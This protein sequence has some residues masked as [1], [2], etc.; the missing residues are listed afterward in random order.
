MNKSTTKAANKIKKWLIT[1]KEAKTEKGVSSIGINV[2][3][4]LSIKS[5]C[6]G[7]KEITKQF[8]FFIAEK[9]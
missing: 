3:R 6:K 2:T 9:I 4:L 5:L 7:E 1:S 8:A